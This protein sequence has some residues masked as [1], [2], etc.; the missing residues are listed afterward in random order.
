MDGVDERAPDTGLNKEGEDRTWENRVVT[1]SNA[2][3]PDD[4]TWVV[5]SLADLVIT[6]KLDATKPES[7]TIVCDWVL[8]Y[9]EL[10]ADCEAKRLVVVLED[11][12]MASVGC[13]VKWDLAW[14]KE[15][16]TMNETTWEM[17]E[18]INNDWK[19]DVAPEADPEA[20]LDNNELLS[21][22]TTENALDDQRSSQLVPY[23]HAGQ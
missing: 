18:V 23:D 7:D 8:E 16:D 5:V 3:L 14:D 12:V 4:L 15:L 6:G 9:E 21:T 11:E 1:L 10:S 22:T 17:L 13:D 2:V 19:F 20:K